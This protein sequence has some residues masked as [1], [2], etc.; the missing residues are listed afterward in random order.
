MTPA[1]IVVGWQSPMVYR[2]AT[3]KI[4]HSFQVTT[5]LSL[6][7]NYRNIKIFLENSLALLVFCHSPMKTNYPRKWSMFIYVYKAKIG[8]KTQA[9]CQRSLSFNARETMRGFIGVDERDLRHDSNSWLSYLCRCVIV[10]RFTRSTRKSQ[11]QSRCTENITES[12]CCR[13]ERTPRRSS[14]RCRETACW[15]WRH[16]C[17][18][19]PS[20][21]ETSPSRNTE[22]Q[23]SSRPMRRSYSILLIIYF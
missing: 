3:L 18:S 16:R 20:P 6:S 8:W 10:S 4:R 12:S 13:R 19:S 1:H 7:I 2:I 5:Y 23:I 9:L 22:R 21:T 17:H 14:R 15:P 11:T